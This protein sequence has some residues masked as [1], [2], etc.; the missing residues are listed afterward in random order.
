[1]ALTS[2]NKF[3]ISCSGI[4]ED[5]SFQIFDFETKQQVLDQSLKERASSMTLTPDNK[6][7]IFGSSL[8]SI[9]MIPLQTTKK[10]FGS[11]DSSFLDSQNTIIPSSKE[12]ST[13]VIPKVFSQELHFGK[14]KLLI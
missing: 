6:F 13:V 8:G 9:T 10:D 1:M 14:K 7:I 11:Q 12:D 4:G 2:D 5:Q 3:L